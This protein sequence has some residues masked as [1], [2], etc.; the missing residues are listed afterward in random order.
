[1]ATVFR[2][3]NPTSTNHHYTT[4]KNEIASLRE[5]TDWNY[6]GAKWETVDGDVNVFRFFNKI[7]GRHLLSSDETEKDN[8]IDNLSNEWNYEGIAFTTDTTSGVAR[9][10]HENGSFFYTNDQTEMSF[11]SDNL[12]HLTVNNSS[13]GANPVSPRIEGTINDDVIDFSSGNTALSAHEGNDVINF[14]GTNG[15]VLE[16][17]EYIDAGNGDDTINISHHK[18][19]NSEPIK[20]Y[21]G[22]GADTF[23]I[24]RLDGLQSS[25]GGGWGETIIEDFDPSEG[26]ELAIFGSPIENVVDSNLSKWAWDDSTILDNGFVEKSLIISEISSE[27]GD[28]TRIDLEFNFFSLLT[29]DY[30]GYVELLGV[31]NEIFNDYIG[32]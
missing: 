12:S 24:Y 31:S 14:V 22:N 29:E 5:N 2:F 15:F 21:G 13:F 8:I 16:K 7:D 20:L 26:D 9:Y 25:T 11:I 1:M 19:S 10:Q 28:Y 6:E 17:R 3:Y 30:S 18:T 4:D 23:N 27:N 32:G